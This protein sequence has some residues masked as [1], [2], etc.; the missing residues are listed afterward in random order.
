MEFNQAKTAGGAR[1]P[2]GV[3]AIEWS[4]RKAMGETKETMGC[5]KNGCAEIAGATCDSAKAQA[6]QKKPCPDWPCVA[7]P[8]GCELSGC[9]LVTGELW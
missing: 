5:A 7:L 8:R 4:E 9:R 1:S 6:R 3:V 2:V